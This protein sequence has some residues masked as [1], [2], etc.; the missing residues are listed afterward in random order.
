VIDYL[1]LTENEKLKARDVSTIG[2]WEMGNTECF[3]NNDNDF[4]WVYN[5]IR[6]IYDNSKH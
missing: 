5:I 3:I 2:H 6:K 4:E 1:D